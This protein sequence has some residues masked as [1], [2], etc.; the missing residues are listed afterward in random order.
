MVIG[1]HLLNI[2]SEQK[3]SHVF[4]FPKCDGQNKIGSL[5]CESENYE[6]TQS[7]K[8]SVKLVSKEYVNSRHI[9]QTDIG[10]DDIY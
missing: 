3:Y 2:G 8:W 1:I 9:T 6:Q 10:W 7:D 4:F 5:N